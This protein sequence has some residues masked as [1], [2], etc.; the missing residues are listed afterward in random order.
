MILICTA[1]YGFILYVLSRLSPVDTT[2]WWDGGAFLPHGAIIKRHPAAPIIVAGWLVATLLAIGS[3]RFFPEEYQLAA[4]L[5]F[6]MLQ[7]ILAA[8]AVLSVVEA[9]RFE[10]LSSVKEVQEAGIVS[11]VKA[12]PYVLLMGDAREILALHEHPQLDPAMEETPYPDTRLAPSEAIDIALQACPNIRFFPWSEE[13]HARLIEPHARALE[14]QA[15]KITETM[16]AEAQTQLTEEQNAEL[17]AQL[18]VA[19]DANKN[20]DQALHDLRTRHTHAITD[21]SRMST[22]QRQE[23]ERKLNEA[24]RRIKVA[25]SAVSE[26]SLEPPPE[27]FQTEV[28]LGE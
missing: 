19:L 9:G 15:S 2:A 3:I 26:A 24:L 20:L 12:F 13:A 10:A 28:R 21:Y 23:E 16:D 27:G 7:A 1:I 17:S 14:M 6:A 25:S 22:T 8:C 11:A 5:G 4:Q 18:R